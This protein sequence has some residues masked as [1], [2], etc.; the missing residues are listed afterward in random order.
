MGVHEQNVPIVDCIPDQ[1]KNVPES[2]ETMIIKDKKTDVDMVNIEEKC[3]DDTNHSPAKRFSED[4]LSENWSVDLKCDMKMEIHNSIL[5]SR[6]TLPTRNTKGIRFSVHNY[7]TSSLNYFY[8]NN[9]H[10]YWY[11]T[12]LRS[13]LEENIDRHL[14]LKI[15]NKKHMF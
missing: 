7:V 13:I 15:L 9:E 10:K 8:I 3:D 14:I 4:E 5:T 1:L 6:S 12:P 11:S 2:Y